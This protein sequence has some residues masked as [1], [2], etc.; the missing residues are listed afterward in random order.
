MI[1]FKTLLLTLA[2]SSVLLFSA[3]V[4]N[5]N[6]PLGPSDSAEGATSGNTNQQE[7]TTSSNS[8]TEKPSNENPTKQTEHL[9]EIRKTKYYS[10]SRFSQ[11][12]SIFL[13]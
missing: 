5:P 12:I 13:Y 11:K 3:C 9:K 8:D 4:N 7:N 1:K 6:A 10:F 2:A